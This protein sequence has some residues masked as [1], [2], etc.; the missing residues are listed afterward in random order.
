MTHTID[1]QTRDM[2][3]NMSEADAIK[4]LRDIFGYKT[5][6]A[7]RIMLAIAL[8]AAKNRMGI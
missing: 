3:I 1:N 4:A 2:L 6:Q 7:Y 8:D 5:Q